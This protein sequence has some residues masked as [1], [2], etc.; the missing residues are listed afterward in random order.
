VP[1]ASSS[2]PAPSIPFAT[3]AAPAAAAAA[4]SELRVGSTPAG[5]PGGVRDSPGARLH[6]VEA[7]TTLTSPSMEDGPGVDEANG[8]RLPVR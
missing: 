4:V 1:N 8:S 7:S 2:V 5:I 6:S 3:G